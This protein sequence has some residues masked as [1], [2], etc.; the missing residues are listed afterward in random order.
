MNPARFCHGETLVPRGTSIDLV[1]F[2]P[3]DTTGELTAPCDSGNIDEL[4]K[5]EAENEPTR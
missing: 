1:D 4:K 3:G 5:D 2:G